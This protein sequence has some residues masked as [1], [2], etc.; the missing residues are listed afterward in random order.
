[1]PRVSIEALGRALGGPSNLQ[2]YEGG[3]HGLLQWSGHTRVEADM[4]AFLNA[5][6]GRRTAAMA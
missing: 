5:C 6:V 4:L 2:V 3:P 1:V